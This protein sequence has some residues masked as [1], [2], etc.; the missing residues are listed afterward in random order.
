MKIKEL[1]TTKEFERVNIERFTNE[2][3]EKVHGYGVVDLFDA[4]KKEF[5]RIPSQKE[6]I[7]RGLM[8]AE[9]FFANN[10]NQWCGYS[11]GNHT[12]T[13]DEDL[14]RAVKS[15][16]DRTYNSYVIEAQV[17][18]Y[19][20]DNYDV[21][22]PRSDKE[23][24]LDYNFGSDITILLEDRF[25]YIHVARDSKYSREHLTKKGDRKS[26]IP[27]NGKKF[28]WTRKWNKRHIGH[29][30]LLYNAR[31]ANQTETVNGLVLF[32]DEYLREYFDKLFSG[33]KYDVLG[34]SEIEEY[35]RFLK[36]NKII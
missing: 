15:R 1:L 25:Y 30:S 23:F 2:Y 12:F 20:R 32:K 10:P 28:Y 22:M 6:Y 4:L 17:E 13:W 36:R 34:E 29:H 7:E 8:R 19:V 33:N 27:I 31:S 3:F 14:I 26:Y 18:E 24:Y 16:L 5:G 9:E 11:L 35:F 21:K